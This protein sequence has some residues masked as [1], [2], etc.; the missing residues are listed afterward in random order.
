MIN[1]TKEKNIQEKNIHDFHTM[2]NQ[3]AQEVKENC[4]FI[5]LGLWSID[6]AQIP[7]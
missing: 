1:N 5:D 2:F 4:S 3:I 6:H 7:A